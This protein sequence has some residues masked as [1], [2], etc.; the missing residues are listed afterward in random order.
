M[1]GL[2]S[3]LRYLADNNYSTQKACNAFFD[4]LLDKARNLAGVTSVAFDGALPFSDRSG[5]A[6]AFGIPGQPDPEVKDM[7]ILHYHVVSIDYFRTLAIPLLRGRLFDEQDQAGKEKTVIVDEAPCSAVF[8][9]S[10]PPWQTD[11][12]CEQHRP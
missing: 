7:P 9:W 3:Q 8:S 11:P 6:F 2:I 4:V 12:R 5:F 1:R 10:G